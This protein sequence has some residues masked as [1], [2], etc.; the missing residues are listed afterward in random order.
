MDQVV[1][2]FVNQ[3]GG[4]GKTTL[5]YS[6][7]AEM[8]NRGKK[9][10]LADADPQGSATAWMNRR[11]GDAPFP[12]VGMA[13]SSLKKNVAGLSKDYDR[14]VIDG[15]PSVV[16]ASI[17]AVQ[18]SDL[19]VVP[20]SPS[21]LDFEASENAF[22]LISTTQE[23]QRAQGLPVGQAVFVVSRAISK[24]AIARDVGPALKTFGYPVL[25]TV[26]RNLVTMAEMPG[27]GLSI[28]EKNPHDPSAIEIRNMTDEIE[29]WVAKIM[30]ADGA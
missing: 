11:E 4:V 8:M 10:I 23:T 6:Y 12:I 18:V 19:I 13:K 29:E 21:M 1:V 5:S 22:D 27:E 15:P 28:V 26:I 3:K 16:D 9:V 17:Q 2:A 25:K 14:V 7:A 30:G 24:T 20:V